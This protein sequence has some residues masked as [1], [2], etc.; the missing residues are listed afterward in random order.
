M[1]SPQESEVPNSPNPDLQIKQHIDGNRNQSIGQML[2]GMV[3]YVSGGQP[4]FGA[5][6]GQKN[7]SDEETTS[8]IG[9]NPYKGLLAFQETDGDRF[10]GRET[11]IADLW[12][13]LRSLYESADAIRLLPIYGPSG[14]GKSSLARAG[15][16][17]ELA[18]RPIPG[19]DTARVAILVPGTNPLEALATILARIVTNDLTPVAKSRE[20]TGELKLSNESGE[21]DGLRRIA[22]VFPDIA[23]SPLIVL[24]DQFE[25]VYTLCE[26]QTERDAFVG[27]LLC[28]AQDKSKRVTVI[29]TFRSDFLGETQKHSQLNRLFT[30]QGYL[31][32]AMNEAELRQAIAKP[33]ELAGHPLDEATINLLIKDTEGREGALPLLQFA[34]TRIWE[35]LLEGKQPTQTLQDIGGVGG[36]LAGEAQRIYDNLKPEEQEIARRVFLGLVQLGEGTKDTRRR[37]LLDSLE[38]HQNQPEELKRV[39]NLFSA[40]GVRLIT[41]SA[42]GS[43]E[44]AEVTHEALFEHW[45]KFQ[46]WLDGSREDIRFQRRLDEAAHHWNEHKRLEGNLWRP[47]DLDLLQEYHHRLSKDMTPLQVEFFQ[48]S[49]QAEENRQEKERRQQLFQKRAIFGLTIISIGAI[50]FAGSALYQMQKA[51]RQRVEQLAATAKAIIP[52]DPVEGAVHAL[53]AAGLTQSPLVQFPNRGVFPAAHGA[54]LDSTLALRERNRLQGHQGFVNSV[55]F[56]HDGTKIVSGSNDNTVRVWDA[57]TGEQIGKPLQHQDKV[58]SVAFNHDGTKIVSGSFDKTV[59][60]WDANTGEQISK[61]LQH[62]DWVWSVAFNHDGTKIVSGSFDNTVRVW[63]ADTGEQIGKPLQHQ[64]WVLSV[65]FNHDGTKIVSGSNDNTVRVWD[66]NTGEQIG[67]PLQHQDKVNSVAFNHD[68]TKIVSGSF[69]NTVRVWDADTGEQIGKPLQHQ[70]WVLSV[71]FNHDGTKIVSGSNDNT[72]RVWD[73]NTGE[74]IGK[75]LQHQDKVN[76]VAFNHDGTKIVSG[77]FDNTVR[78]WDA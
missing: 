12:E 8:A 63:D 43:T 67:K 76:S 14:S 42:T 44:T 66:A 70:D 18:R 41:L 1:S 6:A 5:T 37:A 49:S 11:Q 33:A 23:I 61:P 73:A 71:A 55:A 72:V 75:P 47:P 2:G 4:V 38:S 25:E 62:W 59:R 9:E 74:Q 13:K 46:E 19:Y 28:A 39:V 24:V 32:P 16:I 21:Y 36:A 78:V 20:F 65:A 35:G 10:F 57:N 31:V 30:E 50:T 56:N 15:L 64:D 27:N 40:P 77:S 54:I 7:P 68:G 34:L 58:N 45:G 29:V 60:V 22:N 48:A 17:P 52:N 69:D 53:A 3:V 51:E 26:N